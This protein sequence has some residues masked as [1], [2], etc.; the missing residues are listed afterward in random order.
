[1]QLERFVS[2]ELERGL[3]NALE[4]GVIGDIAGT[5]GIQ[6][7]A[8]ATSALVTVRNGLTKVV[9]AGHVPSAIVLHPQDWAT[10]E[11]AVAS[12][13]AVEHMGLPLDPQRRTLWGVPLAVTV[14]QAAGVGHVLSSGAVALDTDGQGVGIQWSEAT[15]DDLTMNQMRCRVEGRYATSVYQP[16]GVV[17]LDLTA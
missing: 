6:V 12:S 9:V 17:S 13:N 3:R 16:L 2:D 11:L 15:N 7:Q 10:I 4:A 14:G 5:S 1:M 8:W